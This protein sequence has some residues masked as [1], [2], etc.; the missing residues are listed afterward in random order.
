MQLGESVPDG[1]LFGVMELEIPEA[2]LHSFEIHEI[3]ID[4]VPQLRSVEPIP[5][6]ALCGERRLTFDSVKANSTVDIVLQSLN[7]IE[8]DFRAAFVLRSK[9]PAPSFST[10]TT[11]IPLLAEQ[12]VVCEKCKEQRLKPLGP[13]TCVVPKGRTVFFQGTARDIFR[14]H[15]LVAHCE[16][17]DALRVLDIKVGNISQLSS[18]ESLPLKFFLG[19]SETPPLQ[20]DTAQVGQIITVTVHN[21]AD[22]DI[23]A[24]LLF[25]GHIARL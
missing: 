1:A 18:S 12:L 13:G 24:E 3:L 22:H 25:A 2:L 5:T 9:T 15:G 6:R 4:G 11:I 19:L 16:E 21:N 17:P 10:K 8:T 14:P 20:F 7:E 23:N